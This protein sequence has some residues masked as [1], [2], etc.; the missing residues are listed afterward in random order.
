[1]E[2]KAL[3]YPNN[4]TIINPMGDVGVVTLWSRQ[5]Q[6]TDVLNDL[7]IDTSANTSRIAVIGNLY[8]NGIPHM[9]RNLLFNPQIKYLLVCGHDLSNSAQE[10]VNF[11]MIGIEKTIFLNQENYR[12]IGTN[13]IID[14]VVSHKMLGYIE[15]FGTQHLSERKT[16]ED[17]LTFFDKLPHQAICTKERINL[18]IP[19]TQCNRYPSE[20]RSHV[21]TRDTPVQAWEELIFKLVR[22]GYHVKLKK[23]KRIELQNMKVV[24]TNPCIEPDSLKKYNFSLKQF[25]GYQKSILDSELNGSDYTYGNRMRNYFIHDTATIDGLDVCIERLTEDRETRHAYLSLWDSNRD[26]SEGHGCPCMVSVFFRIFEDKLTLTATF[27]THNAKD[28]WLENVYGLMA[29]QEY[30]AVKVKVYT[31]A[32]IVLSH[33]VSI[34]N[35]VLPQSKMIAK[36]FRKDMVI[37]PNGNFTITKDYDTMELVVEQ[38][39]HGTLIK[40]YR[41]KTDLDITRQMVKDCAI[42]DISHALYIGKELSKESAELNASCMRIG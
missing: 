33:S 28:A 39:Y 40:V 9:L 42:S 37:D 30:V 27:R 13:R 20:P 23:G 26:L 11:L 22:F 17:I 4:L 34:D 15:I 3:Y 21:I 35:D 2:F 24:I 25:K 19:I 7:K 29:I 32:I 8:G 14:N 16:E 31:G 41:G 12:I 1:M 38:S 10:L 5:K 6:F 36:N 18:P